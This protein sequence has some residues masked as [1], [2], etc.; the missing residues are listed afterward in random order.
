MTEKSINPVSLAGPLQR[1]WLRAFLLTSAVFVS[2]LIVGIVLT[3]TVLWQRAFNPFRQPSV[4]DVKRLMNDMQDELL[5]SPDQS[6]QLKEVFSS[7]NERM[8]AIRDEV[9][10]KIQN[11]LESV[12]K[13]VEG[14]L[15]PE[16][17]KRWIARYDDIERRLMRFGP[18]GPP[19]GPRP[20]DGMPQGPPGGVQ[21]WPPNDPRPPD[22][23]P[24]GFPGGVQPGPPNGPRLPDGMPQGFPGDAQPGPPNGPRPPDGM[25]QGFPGG[26][27]PG[28]PNGPRPPDGMPKG[29]PGGVQPGPPNGPRPPDDMRGPRPGDDMRGPR[30]GNDMQQGA[31]NGPRPPDGQQP[32]PA[33]SPERPT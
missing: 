24:Q 12:K 17:A 32:P 6:Q 9:D 3:S 30:P 2:G 23:M 28:P 29:F 26:V 4:F 14:V 27:Q 21:P 19:N 25:P 16:Q 33:P 1:P 7:H 15:R 5:L 20:P 31:P 8:K 18:P 10:P 11:E 22:G 13:Q